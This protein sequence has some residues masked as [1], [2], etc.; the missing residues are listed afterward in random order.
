MTNFP[1]FFE[2]LWKSEKWP[3]P[4]PF[5]WQT[6]LAKRGANGDWPESI[7]LPT[8]SGKTASLDAAIFAL[9]STADTPIRMPRRIWLVVDR[10]IVVD[11]AYERAKRIAK[12]LDGAIGGPVKDVA[13]RL[14]QLSG[15]GRPLAVARL[16]GGAWR[17]DGW[18][19]VPSQPAII[20]S[21]VDQVGS[22]LL[23]RAYGHS[24]NTASIYA[25]LVAHDSLV[26]LDEAHC[27]V[28]FLQTLRAVARFRGEQWVEQS[29]KTPFCFSIMSAT[30]P[31]GISEQATFPKSA[32]RAAALNHPLLH[33]RSTA[34][35][36]AALVPVRSDKFVAEA[37]SSARKFSEAHGTRRIALM[38]NRVA[39]AG[40]VVERLREELNGAAQIVLLTGRMRPLD[41]DAL[42]RQWE[43]VLKAGSFETLTKPLILVTTQCLEVGAD[44]SFD[45]L[46]AECAS[47]D[48]LC[49]RF[50]RLDRL[51]TLG[52]SPAIILIR[53]EDTKEPE[54]E[55]TDPI[56]G[57]AIY[58]TWTWLNEPNQRRTDGN[59]DFGIEAMNACI[60]ALR[61]NDEERF[62]GLLAPTPDAPILLPAHLDLLC[63]TSPRATPEP[64][65]TLYLHGK[66]RGMPEVRVV[67]RAD[68][69]DP[70]KSREAG[71]AWIETLSLIPPTSP[72]M[73]TLPLYRFRRWLDEGEPDKASGDVEGMREISD[74]RNGTSLQ[75]S[76]PAFVIYRGRDRSEFTSDARHI[77][78]NDTVILRAAGNGLRGLG[79]TIEQPDGLGTERLDLAERALRQARGR[80]VLRLQRDV[81]APLHENA[82]VARLLDLATEPETEHEEIE[83]AL[84]AVLGEN[85]T[86]TEGAEQ[87]STPVLPAWLIETIKTLLE[88]RFRI[89]VHPAGGLILDGKERR[90]PDS[91]EP[92]D[93]PFADED[94]LTSKWRRPVLL[95]QHT[96]D[97]CSVASDFA[98][99]CLPSQFREIL[100]T[101]AQSHDLG[102]LDRRFQILLRNGDED[103]VQELP[104]LAKS[105]GLPEGY[106]RRTEIEEDTRLPKGFRHEF[107]S[108]QLAEHV[109]LTSGNDSADELMLHLVASH[110]GYGRPFAPVVPD[111]LVAD[112][113][114]EHLSLSG[115]GINATLTPSER[116]TL[117][118]AHRLDSGVADRFW[119]L[120]RR[121]GWWGLAYLEAI[122]RLADW[123]ASSRPGTEAPEWRVSASTR[124]PPLKKFN[125]IPLDALD[126]A[127]PLAFLAAIGTIRTLARAWP[128]A[129][130]GL[131]WRI[132]D[133]GWRP[134]IQASLS[135]DCGDWRLVLCE[136]LTKA[137][138][139]GFKPAPEAEAERSSSQK[140]FEDA[141]RNLRNKLKEIR[142]RKLK[143]GEL[144][145]AKEREVTPL[146]EEMLA[147]RTLW[148]TKLR[149]AVPSLEMALGKRINV[150]PEEFRNFCELA[151]ESGE[152]WIL[153]QLA[154][155]G[156]DA[157]W[158]RKR[159]EVEPTALS[160]VNGSGRQYFLDTARQL[161]SV[162]TKK[163]VFA[164]LF[165]RWRPSDEKLS[166]RWN[167]CEDRRYALMAEDPT[168][169][170]NEPRTIWAANLLAYV[171]LAL[172][173]SAPTRRGLGTVAVVDG[174]GNPS[175]T[176]PMWHAFL[177]PGSLSSLLALRE[178]SMP[179]PPHE[180]LNSLGI[181]LVFRSER[182]EVGDGANVK[183]NFT[184]ARPL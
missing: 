52:V 30:P 109:G 94:D 57:N 101:A 148:L 19:R 143:G 133:A 161:V 120:T 35:K 51:G 66:D 9:A 16:R 43:S 40:Q 160:F 154:H 22:A 111:Q 32:E 13:D 61:E 55:E 163:A 65:I 104:P 50:G 25:G 110:H 146:V 26:L 98:V 10:R 71:A 170:G 168:A 159:G 129:Q 107:L 158:D 1:A 81:L 54:D 91:T 77:R 128:D 117:P 124:T 6:M 119:R 42:V 84:Q 62:Q 41:R 60:N 102:K 96:S 156:S 76:R 121:F 150:P 70:T 92:E 166:M 20:C 173:P 141:R 183:L 175:F 115:M 89:D 45:A 23:F 100:V 116:Q 179:S 97:V 12:K 126:G 5:P 164:A 139:L 182:I 184:P 176:W 74:E 99:R 132:H 169:G 90:V 73:L 105:E 68:L 14:R 144:N 4:E 79:Q 85:P 136:T 59:V 152:Q 44:F 108:M 134:I 167:P 75:S 174:P 83:A 47:I 49:Q 177:S 58:E 80:V 37:V 78:P 53:E 181:P 72:E 86:T 151:I 172:L 106:R 147:K 93:D 137:L 69:P 178:L 103:E 135:K 165:E 123:Q 64:D 88:D 18:A 112:G 180:V 142:S 28:P 95:Q 145:E 118:P 67:I 38:V 153:D 8:A 48:A 138:N 7:N 155:F 157:C 17:D 162:V 2:A 3:E 39:T 130:L 127:N 36:L 113:K 31:P 46:I 34:R 131:A 149:C 56:Y 171:G 82:S 33:Q 140:N 125:H 122:F 63:Q 15:T 29:L 21:T 114:V 27:A 11:E 24:D 87:A